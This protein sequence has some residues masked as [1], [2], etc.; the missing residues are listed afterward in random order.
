MNLREAGK[1]HRRAVRIVCLDSDNRVLLLCWNREDRGHYWEPPGGGI[2][3][4]ETPLEAA[5]R[6]LREET[7]IDPRYL[8]GEFVDVDRDFRWFGAPKHRT[9]QFFLARVPE[10]FE[11]R[12]A[13]LTEVESGALRGSGWFSIAEFGELTE[14]VEP[15]QLAEVIAELAG[16]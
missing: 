10:R 7:G 12:P 9:E 11:L 8:T 4:E 5:R 2:E 1:R 14:R 16:N 3:H 13:E 6:E 15:E